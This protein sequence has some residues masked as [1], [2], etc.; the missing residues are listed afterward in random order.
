MMPNLSEGFCCSRVTILPRRACASV[1]STA[2]KNN[3]QNWTCKF[4]E[5]LYAMNLE[6]SYDKSTILENYINQDYHV[7]SGGQSSHCDATVA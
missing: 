2:K 1:S 6:T 7:Q 4:K 3:E 5:I